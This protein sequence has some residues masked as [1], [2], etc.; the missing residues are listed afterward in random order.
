VVSAVERRTSTTTRAAGAPCP[1]GDCLIEI[2][3]KAAFEDE[4]LLLRLGLR[5][6]NRGIPAVTTIAVL[7][8]A[9]WP[10]RR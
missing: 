9:N 1:V 2:E 4:A 5:D 10:R 6:P 8:T 7:A 3:C